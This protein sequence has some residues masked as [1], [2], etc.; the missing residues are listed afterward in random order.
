MESDSNSFEDPGKSN[1][2]QIM[3]SLTFIKGY[4]SIASVN[5]L[6]LPRH[7]KMYRRTMN[8]KCLIGVESLFRVFWDLCILG[9]LVFQ[10]FWIPFSLGLNVPLTGA[11]VYIDIVI[12][13]SFILDIILNFNT[14]VND[15]GTIIRDRKQIAKEYLK[16]WFWIDMVSSFPYDWVLSGSFGQE[17]EEDSSNLSKAPQLLRIIKVL[18]FVRMLR[19]VRLAKLKQILFRIEDYMSN[20]FM[21]VMFTVSKMGIVIFFI[22]H[23]SA[24]CFFYVSESSSTDNPNS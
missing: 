22:A 14:T 6:I 19:L 7:M 12:T 4:D 15:R 16:L 3:R 10:A 21:Y 23:L 18:R 5:P 11:L 9:A 17:E 20:E 2:K 24:C 13:F 8:G 1:L